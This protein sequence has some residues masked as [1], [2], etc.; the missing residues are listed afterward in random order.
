[1][2][3]LQRFVSKSR[4]TQH[5]LRQI[6]NENRKLA[7]GKAQQRQRGQQPAEGKKKPQKASSKSAA[8]SD[9]PA[10]DEAPKRGQ[11]ISESDKVKLI[12]ANEDKIKEQAL[13]HRREMGVEE[14]E[15]GNEERESAAEAGR[16]RSIFD[17]GVNAVELR[18]QE[19]LHKYPWAKDQ[20]EAAIANPE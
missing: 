2:L 4:A 16:R 5:P 10:D 6:F 15:E 9:D 8:R 17:F 12:L 19:M 14:V 1:M 13:K 7:Q 11:K 20:I 18:K 3:Q